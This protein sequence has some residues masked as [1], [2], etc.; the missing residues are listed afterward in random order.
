MSSKA[1]ADG[2]Y[3]RRI[4]GNIAVWLGRADYKTVYIG[5]SLKVRRHARPGGVWKG[6]SRVRMWGNLQ[7]QSRAGT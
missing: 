1:V 6:L 4:S 7:T 2:G 3:E 5:K